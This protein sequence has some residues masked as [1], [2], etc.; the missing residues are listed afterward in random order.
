[1]ALVLGIILVVLL[2]KIIKQIKRVTDSVEKTVDSAH[3]VI[4]NIKKWVSPALFQALIE[5]FTS[6]VNE[7][8]E[9]K[10]GKKR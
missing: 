9:E 4:D 5:K 6:F 3:G 2:I 7:K 8:K 10:D 1:V